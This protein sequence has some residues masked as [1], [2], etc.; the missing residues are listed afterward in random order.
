MLVPEEEMHHPVR[1][2]FHGYPGLADDDMVDHVIEHNLM[3]DPDWP[4]GYDR[5][6]REPGRL[7]GWVFM[8]EKLDGDDA[9]DAGADLEEVLKARG[10]AAYTTRFVFW[11]AWQGARARYRTESP[12]TQWLFKRPWGPWILA[13]QSRNC[14][15]LRVQKRDVS[16]T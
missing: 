1:L 3:K 4:T 5:W 2:S 16:P 15:L 14:I 10:F 9:L 13:F 7:Y 6:Q 8:S 11:R 12:M